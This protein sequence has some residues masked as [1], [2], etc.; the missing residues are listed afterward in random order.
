MTSINGAVN[1]TSFKTYIELRGLVDVLYDIQE[2]RM[3]TA[4]RLRSMPKETRQL[5]VK[6]L[7]A[8]EKQL[9]DEIQVILED[10]P[11]YRAFL[12]RVRGVGPR[13][14]GSIIAQTM[15]RFERVSA[16]EY[17]ALKKLYGSHDI[18]DTPNKDASHCLVDTQK[19]N[20][21]HIPLGAQNN[22]ASHGLGDTQNSHASQ[23]G[24][25]TH[26][27]IA[28]SFEQ[29]QLAQKTENGGYLIPVRRGIEAF[30]TASKYWAWWGLHVVDGGAAKRRRGENINWNPTMRTLAWKIGKQFVI[31]GRGYRQIYDNE[32]DRLNAQRLPVGACSRY[33]ECKA[34]LKNRKEPACKGHIDAMARRKAVKLFIAH[35]YQ[36]WRGL[37]GLPSRPP[38]VMEYMGHTGMV[39]AE[40]VLQLD[41]D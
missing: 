19:V 33:E 13:L 10:E 23:S 4:N 9:T 18:L 8:L 20:A 34:K 24:Y 3:R 6:P 26:R 36:T 29:F 32:K 22:D 35:L 5:R 2:V 11:I 1:L 12:S 41:Q 37:E 40:E 25:D 21:S 27:D 15:I 17:G 16:E 31:Q 7:A 28:Y 38:Y 39:T 14:S 30:D